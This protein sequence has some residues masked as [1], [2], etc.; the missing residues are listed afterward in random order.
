[1]VHRPVVKWRVH[2]WVVR[3]GLHQVIT[4]HSVDNNV[5]QLK[6]LVTI[7]TMV[8]GDGWLVDGP[9][10]EWWIDNWVLGTELN[11]HSVLLSLVQVELIRSNSNLGQ[12]KTS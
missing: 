12:A 2:D 9:V 7:I 6:V 10:V 3:F 8:V 5:S 11:I 1:M 4:I